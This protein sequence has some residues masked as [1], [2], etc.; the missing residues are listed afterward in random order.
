MSVWQ[1]YKTEALVQKRLTTHLSWT[2]EIPPLKV[3]FFRLKFNI[4]VLNVKKQKQKNP[5]HHPHPPKKNTQKML[6]SKYTLNHFESL[7]VFEGLLVCWMNYL[8]SILDNSQLG[9]ILKEKDT[10]NVSK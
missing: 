10:E 7:L 5:S 3:Y 6:G 9:E 1:I 2:L 8:Y 4:F